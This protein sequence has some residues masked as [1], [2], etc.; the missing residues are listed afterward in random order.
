[1][2]TGGDVDTVSEEVSPFHHHIAHMHSD[3]EVSL[4]IL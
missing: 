2:Q 4:T 3:A 1:L